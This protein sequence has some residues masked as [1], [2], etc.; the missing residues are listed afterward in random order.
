MIAGIFAVDE[1]GAIGCFR[2]AELEFKIR[3]QGGK[4]ATGVTGNT[5]ILVTDDPNSTTGKAQKARQL[6][7]KIYTPDQFV[8]RYKL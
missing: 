6:G 5:T 1:G 8:K 3:Q 4:I 7:I 2:S